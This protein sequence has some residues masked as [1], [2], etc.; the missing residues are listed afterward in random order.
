MTKAKI[1]LTMM[2]QEDAFWAINERAQRSRMSCSV[3]IWISDLSKIGPVVVKIEQGDFLDVV[4]VARAHVR[5]HP[6]FD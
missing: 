2:N 4:H 6:T 1:G 5:M 3:S